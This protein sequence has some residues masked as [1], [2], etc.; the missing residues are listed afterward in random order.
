LF[1]SYS[2]LF[3]NLGRSLDR[4]PLFFLFESQQLV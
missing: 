3:D 1:A 2:P 4:C